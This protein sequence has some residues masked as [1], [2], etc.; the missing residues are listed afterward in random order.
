[1][2]ALR[3]ACPARS[4][5]KSKGSGQAPAGI[6]GEERQRG[7]TETEKKRGGLYLCLAILDSRFRGN[8]ASPV[9]PSNQHDGL[10]V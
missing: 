10:L 6:R 8:D 2:L 9:Y 1:M 5:A 7:E 3:Q 4:A